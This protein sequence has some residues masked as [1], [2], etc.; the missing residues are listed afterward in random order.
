MAA[1]VCVCERERER[2][3]E[4]EGGGGGG[5]TLDITHCPGPVLALLLSAH[6]YGIYIHSYGY[7]HPIRSSLK[8]MISALQKSILPASPLDYSRGKKSISD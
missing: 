4:R 2:E 5:L 3:R 8:P 1:C 6:S 7:I